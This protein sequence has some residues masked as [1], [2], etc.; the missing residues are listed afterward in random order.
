MSKRITH[1]KK[2]PKCPDGFMEA[3]G[4]VFTSDPPW[5]GHDC[6]KCGHQERYFNE[7]WP[8]TEVIYD[9]EETVIE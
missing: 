9:A 8:W 4:M 3:N 7:K 5:Y 2:C 6:D 1:K